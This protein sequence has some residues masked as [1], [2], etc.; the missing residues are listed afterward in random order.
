LATQGFP[1]KLPLVNDAAHLVENYKETFE[2]QQHCSQLG[3]KPLADREITRI[4]DLYD[5]VIKTYGKSFGKPY[6]WIPESILKGHVTFA[7]IEKFERFDKLRPYYLMACH[8]VHSGPKAI[9]FR[10]GIFKGGR[11]KTLLLAGAS[12][13]GLADPGQGAAISL[14]QITSCLLST[15]Q[16]LGT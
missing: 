5:N 1:D 7:R 9:T 13:Y 14:S 3:Y 2:Y 10:L 12:N 16:Q 11:H 15:G 8:N 6:G 4:K